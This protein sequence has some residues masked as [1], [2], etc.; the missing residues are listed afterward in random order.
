M[1]VGK[2]PVVGKV[3]PVDPAFVC[4]TKVDKNNKIGNWNPKWGDWFTVTRTSDNK[5]VTVVR[6]DKGN[7]AAGWGL[8]LQFACCT[9]HGG[10]YWWWCWWWW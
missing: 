7:P 1:T 2:G 10:T 5:G 8:N 3:F 9:G 4:P 6:S